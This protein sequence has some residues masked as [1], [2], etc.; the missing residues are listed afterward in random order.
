MLEKQVDKEHYNFQS[1]MNKH[2]WAS[3]WHQVDE[4]IKVEP[5]S[6][7]EV[8][9][10]AGVFKAAAQCFGLKVETLDID[11]ELNPDHI[12]SVFDLPFK[13]GAFD[14][15]CAFQMLEHLP[16]DKSI[17]ALKEMSRVAK[18]KVIISLPNAAT[19]WPVSVRIPSIGFVEF[20]LPHPRLKLPE[21]EFDGEHY[22][23]INTAGYSLQSVKERI[24][25]LTSLALE[26]DFR[27]QENSYHHFFVFNSNRVS[28]N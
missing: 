17:D 7:L 8:G 12:A 5:K 28:Q 11:P 15:V 9:P 14:V 27:V 25:N 26:K 19:R 18:K 23:E 22:W 13:D 4:I 2:R 24:A 21:H 16:F 10:G 20:T 3:T 1:Y 6:V